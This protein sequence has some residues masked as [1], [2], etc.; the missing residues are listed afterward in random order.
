MSGDEWKSLMADFKVEFLDYLMD[1]FTVPELGDELGLYPWTL[2]MGPNPISPDYVGTCNPFCA[3]TEGKLIDQL[4][5]D[6]P[7][8]SDVNYDEWLNTL[9]YISEHY[10]PMRTGHVYTKLT[11]ELIAADRLRAITY[12]H[13]LLDE[14]EKGGS[15]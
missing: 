14:S 3:C 4:W 13:V 8:D 5:H 15:S 11:D 6:F 2:C 1:R 7:Y 12:T 10:D 9:A